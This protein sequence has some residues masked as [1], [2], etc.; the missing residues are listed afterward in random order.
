MHQRAI[1]QVGNVRSAQHAT[2]LN[3]LNWSP[4]D[5]AVIKLIAKSVNQSINQSV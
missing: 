1:Q 5:W 2:P 4:S 3:T